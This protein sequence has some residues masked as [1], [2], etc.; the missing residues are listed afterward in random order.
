MS[1][2]HSTLVYG[3]IVA[4]TIA[5][6]LF[7]IPA[8]ARKGGNWHVRIGRIY[9]IAM[10]AVA[11]TAFVASLLSGL[12]LPPLIGPLIYGLIPLAVGV[13]GGLFAGKLFQ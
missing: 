11:V 10:Y 6:I 12:I 9:V 13:V 3:H 7:W 8:L 4:G 1:T 2:L 5:L